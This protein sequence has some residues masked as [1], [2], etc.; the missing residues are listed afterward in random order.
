M[1]TTTA[2]ARPEA[3]QMPEDLRMWADRVR[4]S[5]T[6]PSLRST[7]F[8]VYLAAVVGVLAAAQLVGTNAQGVDPFRAERAWWF[9]TLLTIGY[10]VSRGLAKAGS[11]WRRSEE[12]A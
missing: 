9:I 10:L 5:E 11:Q 12:Q 2:T 4:G 1:S 8:W 3:R 7:E 6:K